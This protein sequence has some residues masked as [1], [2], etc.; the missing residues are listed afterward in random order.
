MTSTREER[1][2]RTPLI[3]A[4]CVGLGLGLFSLA[5]GFNRPTI[6]NMRTIDLI[7]LL[8]T[9]GCLG[10]GLVGLVGLIVSL[11]GRRTG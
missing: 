6:A 5:T 4:T 8:A 2:R 10:V 3:V 9:G 7:H 11:V 1:L